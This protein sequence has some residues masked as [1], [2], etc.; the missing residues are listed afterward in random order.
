MPEENEIPLWSG[1]GL[2]PVGTVCEAKSCRT[3]TFRKCVVLVHRNDMAV[4]SFL[5]QEELQWVDTFRTAEQA[6]IEERERHNAILEMTGH[7]SFSDK[8]AI[9]R[10]CA[11]L[12]DAGY[13]KQVA[14]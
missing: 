1:E 6:A 7:L 3:K 2:P 11:S 9:T 14:P 8:E 13:R 5:D 4:V 10:T 12:Y